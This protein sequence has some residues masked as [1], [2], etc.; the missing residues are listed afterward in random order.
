VIYCD[1]IPHLETDFF[2]ARVDLIS[3]AL[4]FEGLITPNH[5]PSSV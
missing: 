1:G 5:M 4:P 3:D 2:L